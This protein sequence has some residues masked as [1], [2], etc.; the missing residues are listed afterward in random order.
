EGVHPVVSL[1]GPALPSLALRQC[2]LAIAEDLRARKVFYL[3]HVSALEIDGRRRSHL[4]ADEAAELLAANVVLNVEGAVLEDAIRANRRSGS[5]FA[6]LAGTPGAIFNE[7]FTHIGSGTLFTEAY[8]NVFRPARLSDVYDIGLLLKPYEEDG[9]ILPMTEERIA[10]GI[11]HFFVFTV[12]DAVVAAARLI[13]YGVAAEVGKFCTLPRF[14]GRGRARKL[15]LC[16]IERARA[17]GKE[18]VF[19]LSTSSEMW[20]FFRSLEFIEVARESLP[21]SWRTQYDFTRPS[22]AFRLDL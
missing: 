5:E 19:A 21:E 1:E 2:G 12:N 7:V 18:Y 9:S 17:L 8:P 3:T 14:R 10:E 15:A 16:L 13:D 11:E 6:L 22:K 4:S 20:S